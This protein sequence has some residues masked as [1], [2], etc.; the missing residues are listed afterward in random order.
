MKAFVL[1]ALGGMV[2]L[3]LSSPVFAESLLKDPNG[4]Q[5]LIWGASLRDRSDLQET[6]S[7]KV[8]EGLIGIIS[9]YEV[10]GGAAPIGDV[11][12]DQLLFYAINGKF[13][14]A[15]IHY[16]GLEH[17]KQL[18]AYLQSEFGPLDRSLNKRGYRIQGVWL[19]E[20]TGIEV[21]YRTDTDRGVVFFE[22]RTIRPN[23]VDLISEHGY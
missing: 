20:N 10:R 6:E 17:H 21:M 1:S 2:L 22:S 12:I 16:S 5:N 4:F 9:V 11:P 13:V 19:G 15:V 14:R 18:L 3:T 7:T 8:N 23:F